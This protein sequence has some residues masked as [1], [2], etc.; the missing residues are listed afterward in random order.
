VIRRDGIENQVKASVMLIHPW[1][2]FLGAETADIFLNA[3]MKKQ[4]T[5]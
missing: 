2:M 4:K 3:K 5:F 1:A